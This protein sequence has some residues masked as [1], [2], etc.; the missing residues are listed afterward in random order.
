MDRFFDA[1]EWI[2]YNWPHFE[3]MGVDIC[4][5]IREDSA[6]ADALARR[7]GVSVTLCDDGVARY[8]QHLWEHL[9]R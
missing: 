6:R 1:S 9:E 3:E 5:V 7:M 8:P 4:A 2:A